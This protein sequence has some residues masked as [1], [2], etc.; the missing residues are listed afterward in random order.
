MRLPEG[1]FRLDRSPRPPTGETDWSGQ[2]VSIEGAGAARTI[3]AA[4]GLLGPSGVSTP[5]LRLDGAGSVRLSGLTFDGGF[6]AAPPRLARPDGE[7]A[8]LLEIHHAESV[9]LRDVATRRSAHGRLPFRGDLAEL[10]RSGPAS[11]VAC[12]YVRIESG[13]IAFPSFGDGW[14]LID[15]ETVDVRGLSYDGPEELVP[16]AVSTPLNVVGPKTGAIVLRDCRFARARGSAVNLGGRGPVH[17]SGCE[18]RGLIGESN[19]VEGD[20]SRRPGPRAFGKGVDLGSEHQEDLFPD[21][22]PLDDVLIERCSFLDLFSYSLRLVKRASTPASNVRIRENRFDNGFRGVELIN[23]R[24][25]VIERNRFSRIIKY[26]P[27]SAAMGRPLLIRS[28]SDIEVRENEFDGEAEARFRTLQDGDDAPRQSDVGIDL[29]NSRDVSIGSNT[30]YGF[31]RAQV[32]VHNRRGDT[33]D[34]TRVRVSGNRFA[35]PRNADRSWRAVAV[36]GSQDGVTVDGNV[37]ES[38]PRDRR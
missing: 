12:G 16:G 14:W 27:S 17:V 20:P 2:A 25:A 23:V 37:E 18:F 10:G 13:A 4:G 11:L 35:R 31:A 26:T 9:L 6:D 3:L 38:T 32:L 29:S 7:R 30:F 5:I 21:H 8:S 28:C 22:P 24:R 19:M 1:T 33:P 15:C 34:M 36:R